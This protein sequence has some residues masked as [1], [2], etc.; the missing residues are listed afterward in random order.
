MS[1]YKLFIG[2][3]SCADSKDGGQI[4]ASGR[5]ADKAFDGDT[6]TYYD[7]KYALCDTYAG[8]GLTRPCVLTRIRYYP[9]N[10]SY[11]LARLGRS[12]IQG[13]NASDFSDAVD[14]YSFSGKV[15]ADLISNIRWQNRLSELQFY[16]WLESEAAGLAAG[17]ADLTL[18]CGVTPSVTLTWSPVQYGST[19]KIERKTGDG[20]WENVVSALPIATTTMATTGSSAATA[21]PASPLNA[22]SRSI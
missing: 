11:T 16:G 6:A 19:Y 1:G 12:V 3:M 15:P 21:P 8:Y 20:A 14:I 4:W 17:A 9:R 18:T 7:P 5:E 10:E 2:D 22:R 13:A